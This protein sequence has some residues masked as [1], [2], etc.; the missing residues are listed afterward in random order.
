MLLELG[1]A[2]RREPPL[3]RR[4]SAGTE[5]RGCVLSSTSA[6]APVD[7]TGVPGVLDGEIRLPPRREQLTRPRVEVAFELGLAAAELDPQHVGEQVVIAVLLTRGV[8]RH[9][10]QVRPGELL[11]HR[12]GTRSFEHRIA[13]RPVEVLQHGRPGQEL[14]ACPPA[15]RR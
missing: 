13:A 6:T 3:D 15:V 5:V 10:E 1:R 9:D 12:P 14:D 11:E 7:V 2:E 8:Q 4:G